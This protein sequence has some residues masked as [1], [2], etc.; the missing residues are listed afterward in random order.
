[1]GRVNIWRRLSQEHTPALATLSIKVFHQLVFEIPQLNEFISHEGFKPFN[2]VSII[3]SEKRLDIVFDRKEKRGYDPR[4]FF[5]S[6]PCRQ[7]DWQLSF[8][9]Q[10]SNQLPTL[11]S[12]AK[13]FTIHNIYSMPTGREDVDP[14]QRL[15]LFRSLPSL[16]K[17]RVNIEELV[18]DVVHALANEYMAAGISPGQTLLHLEG[19]QKSPSAIDAAKRFVASRKLA[20]RNILL[21]G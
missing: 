6:V 20:N 9:I 17:L 16:S 7:L 14:A 13:L 19:Y 8:T 2:E 3:L 15:E 21:R 10:I 5:L 12:S 4:G 11:L 18:P 1:M